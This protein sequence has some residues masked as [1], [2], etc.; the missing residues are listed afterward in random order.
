MKRVLVT[1]AAG[2]IGRQTLPPLQAAGF[3][4]HAVD[5]WIPPWAGANDAARWHQADVLTVGAVR[6]I[7]E[8]LRPT[9]LLHLAWEA[10]PGTYWN[11]PANLDWLAASLQLIRDFQQTGGQRMVTA[12]TSAE[13]DWTTGGIMREADTM[14]KPRGLYG[15]CKNALR[16]VGEGFAGLQ[17]LSWGWARLF[18]VYGPHEKAGR[19]IPK[20]VCALLREQPVSMDASNEQRDFMCVLDVGAALAALLGS[21]VQ[22]PVNVAS[23][24]LSSIHDVV[25]QV[26]LQVGASHLLHWQPPVARWDEP[27]I[28]GA[29]THRLN[30]EVGW[31][32]AHSLPDGVKLTC[33]WWREE[34]EQNQAK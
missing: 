34:L 32:P 20:V 10:T 13:Y 25:S 24:S 3:E 6:Q 22:G 17:G 31:R 28:L 19:L 5:R 16:V 26:A 15:V 23:G 8:S 11:A 18:C 14:L 29:A 33:Q 12:G 9:H 2:F 30:R 21:E 1:G 7:M 27:E 4:V